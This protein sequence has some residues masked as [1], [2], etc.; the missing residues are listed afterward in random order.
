M[1]SGISRDFSSS[2]LT[3]RA[4]F[5]H[6]NASRVVAHAN[7]REQATTREREA[8]D[9]VVVERERESLEIA[10][11]EIDESMLSSRVTAR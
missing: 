2:L 8:I 10:S 3:R 7:A 5:E 6:R 9:G 11:R 4:R 1:L